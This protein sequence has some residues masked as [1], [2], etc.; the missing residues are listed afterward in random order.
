MLHAQTG[1]YFLLPGTNQPG[2]DGEEMLDPE[3]H[4]SNG[5]NLKYY[6]FLNFNASECNPVCGSCPSYRALDPSYNGVVW[7]KEISY[8]KN[9]VLQAELG[10]GDI[11]AMDNELWSVNP[12]KVEVCYP[13][14]FMQDS[15]KYHGSTLDE[16]YEEYYNYWLQRGIDMTNAVKEI[17][18]QIGVYHHHENTY[19]L[20][21]GMFYGNT[22]WYLASTG[23]PY[24]S[25][26]APSPEFYRCS[27]L[28]TCR[29]VLDQDDFS[30]A[31]VWIS[32]SFSYHD[33]QYPKYPWDPKITQ[34]VGYW[35][36]Q[37]GVKGIIEYPGPY[38]HNIPIEYYMAHAQ[39]LLKGFLENEDP[40]E[41]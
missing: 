9:A 33:Q 39:A 18:P 30:G 20:A 34:K 19:K 3:E 24:G 27:N 12:T 40:G 37:E 17:N 16:R 21:R 11:V 8:L 41:I 38:G 13:G 10:P 36:R 6:D 22:N 31:V 23:M 2:G 26:D 5:Q 35:L 1:H 29:K 7:Q 15:G 32:F 14:A 25:G 4:A 28:T